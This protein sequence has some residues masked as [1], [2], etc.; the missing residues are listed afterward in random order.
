MSD[1]VPML[2]GSSTMSLVYNLKLDM[3]MIF[4]ELFLIEIVLVFLVVL[5]F[6]WKNDCL[7]KT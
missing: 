6:F 4:P 7:A 3:M 2:C 1:F 5:Y